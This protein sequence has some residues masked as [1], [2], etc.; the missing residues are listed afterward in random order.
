MSNFSCGK[1]LHIFHG[2][3]CVKATIVDYGPSCLVENNAGGI[4]SHNNYPS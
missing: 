3:K 1:Y 2:A 4:Q